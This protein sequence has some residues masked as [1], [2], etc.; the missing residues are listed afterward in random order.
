M[1]VSLL[2]E[3]LE[4]CRSDRHELRNAGEVPVRV[5]DLRVT[6]VGRER[7]DALIDVGAGSVPP[8]KASTG[9]RVPEVVDARTSTDRCVGHDDFVEE[10]PHHTVHG[11]RGE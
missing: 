2:P 4:P 9:E 10:F 6:E 3:A 1:M 7:S 11:P 5:R 8:E